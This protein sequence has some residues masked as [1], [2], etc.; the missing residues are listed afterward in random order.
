M[1]PPQCVLKDVA[2]GAHSESFHFPLLCPANVSAGEKKRT[3][4]RLAL[5]WS[6]NDHFWGTY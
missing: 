1:H 3:N 5:Y 6:I 2:G 4:D